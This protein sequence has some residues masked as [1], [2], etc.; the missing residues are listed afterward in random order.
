MNLSCSFQ[1]FR[2]LLF[3]RFGRTVNS[4]S[5]LLSSFTVDV[6]FN[7]QSNATNILFKNLQGGLSDGYKKYVAEN[8]LP[9]DTYTEDGIALFR[10]QGTGPENMQAV[11]LEP[12]SLDVFI[13]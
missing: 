6:Y 9:D 1:S 7:F 12:V 11:Q 10:V 4:R 8:E 5:K 3:L 2:A 13:F